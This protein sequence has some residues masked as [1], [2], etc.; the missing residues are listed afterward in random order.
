MILAMPPSSVRNIKFS[1]PL[2]RERNFI[3]KKYNMGSFSKV[4][5]FYDKRYWHDNGFS[6]E[7]LSDCHDGPACNVYD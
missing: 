1:P 7:I 6:G 3:C 5:L 4:F 2:S